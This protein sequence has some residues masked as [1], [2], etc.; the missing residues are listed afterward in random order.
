M[1]RESCGTIKTNQRIDRKNFRLRL[2]ELNKKIKE[3]AK[4]NKK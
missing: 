2:W 3:N 4:N 1:K